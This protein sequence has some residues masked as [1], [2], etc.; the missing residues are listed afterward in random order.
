MVGYNIG[1][2]WGGVRVRMRGEDR[3]VAEGEVDVAD[4]HYS[5]DIYD[6]SGIKNAPLRGAA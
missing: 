1:P 3:V 6:Y 5:F 4:G 2:P